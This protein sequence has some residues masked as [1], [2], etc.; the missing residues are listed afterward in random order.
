MVEV[1]LEHK[2]DEQ[3][4][5]ELSEKKVTP[6][7]Q[8][9]GYLPW[10]GKDYADLP[11][12]NKIFILG[13]SVY[14]G[15]NPDKN[16]SRDIINGHAIKTNP[17]RL[18]RNMSWAICGEKKKK[19][20]NPKEFWSKVCFN[21]LVQTKMKTKKYRPSTSDYEN[22]TEYIAK[23]IDILK[24]AL[25]I[26]FNNSDVANSFKEIFADAKLEV[27]EKVGRIKPKILTANKLKILFIKHA[28]SYFSWSKWNEFINKNAK[29][30]IDCFQSLENTN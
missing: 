11:D 4:D 20:L 18:F 10:I 15:W 19:E 26:C 3:F 23:Q 27:K 22:G 13:E 12:K 7:L 2:S 1:N 29:E 14:N 5:K 17:S 24:P 30:N 8:N 16:A 25:V 28:S 6:N 21:N 9:I